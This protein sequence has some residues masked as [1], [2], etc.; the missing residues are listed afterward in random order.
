MGR[1]EIQSPFNVDSSKVLGEEPQERLIA[2]LHSTD[3]P[4]LDF[5]VDRHFAV[6]I[7]HT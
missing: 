4:E 3:P 2:K 5:F 6:R 1:Y 7:S